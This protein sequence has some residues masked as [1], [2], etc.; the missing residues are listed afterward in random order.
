MVRTAHHGSLRGSTRLRRWFVR[1]VVAVMILLQVA[2]GLVGQQGYLCVCA[3][4]VTVAH[5]DCCAQTP[6]AT[7]PPSAACDADCQ[8]IPLPDVSAVVI[9]APP[10]LP[11][12][13]QVPSLLVIAQIVWPRAS[14]TPT[15][16]RGVPPPDPL[17]RMLRTVILTC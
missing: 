6:D 12:A 9:A 16:T 8:L 11:D 7:D 4:S 1:A 5:S 13:A 10:G 2:L 17:A 3:A 15:T 14:W